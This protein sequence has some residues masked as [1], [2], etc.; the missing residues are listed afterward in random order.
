MRFFGLGEVL[1]CLKGQ[2]HVCLLIFDLAIGNDFI[3]IFFGW[4]DDEVK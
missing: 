3:L 2:D 1:R 4:I